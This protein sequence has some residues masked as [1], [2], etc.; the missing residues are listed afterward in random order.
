MRSDVFNAYS[1]YYDLLYRDKDYDAEV[2]YVSTLLQKHGVVGKDILEFGSGTGRH[3]RIL[4]ASG[5]RVLGI[6]RSADMAA[7]ACTT[8]D[9]TCMQGDIRKIDLSRQFDAIVSLFHVL[10]YQTRNEDILAVFSKAAKHLRSGG[11]FVFDV[12]YT[13][14]V[15]AQQPSIRIKRMSDESVEVTRIAEPVIFV[16]ENRVD[17]HYTIIVRDKASGL[18]EQ[19]SEIHPM[20]HYSLL[21]IDLLAGLNCFERIGTEEF[22]T[23]KVSGEDTWGVCLILRRI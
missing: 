14:A 22:L 5:Y 19:L 23:G 8:E 20:R 18:T 13:P 6:E 16:N 9:F 4:A 2:E 17:V 3:G 15:L 7:Q 1:K 11:L 10:S 12:W 21:E